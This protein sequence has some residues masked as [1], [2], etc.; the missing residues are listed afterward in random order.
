VRGSAAKNLISVQ[1]VNCSGCV[2][3]INVMIPASDSYF[4]DKKYRTFKI[5]LSVP[6]K[7][8]SRGDFKVYMLARGKLLKSIMS[9][10]LYLYITGLHTTGY[11]THI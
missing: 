11:N 6:L 5:F 8:A 3:T 10:Q 2:V 1:C 4:Y 7:S 9:L